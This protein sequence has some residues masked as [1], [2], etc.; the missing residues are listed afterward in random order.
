MSDWFGKLSAAHLRHSQAWDSGCLTDLV[1]WLGNIYYIYFQSCTKSSAYCLFFFHNK[2]LYYSNWLP[3]FVLLPGKLAFTF[4]FFF[5]GKCLLFNFHLDC[6]S[7]SRVGH[8][9][10]CSFTFLSWFWVLYAVIGFR[11]KKYS[12]LS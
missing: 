11:S 2:S 12:R 8:R 5:F 3:E 6:V 1:C 7:Y 10:I 9:F 4:F